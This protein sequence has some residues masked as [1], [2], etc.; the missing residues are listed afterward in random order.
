MV[1]KIGRGNHLKGVLIYNYEKVEQD[2]GNVLCCN[3]MIEPLSG[4]FTIPL[5]E[6]SFENYLIANNKTEKPILHISLNPNPKDK[7]SDKQFE[8]IAQKYMDEMGYGNQPYVVFSHTDI[9]RK[10]IHIVS[11]CV[12]ENGKRISDSFEKR[13][14]M[15]VCRNL[16]KEF[17]LLPA[18]SSENDKELIPLNKVDAQQPNL[19]KQIASALYFVNENYHFQTLGEYKAMLSFFNITAEEVKGTIDGQEKRGLVYF[20]TD[21][22]G[23]KTSHAFKSSRFSGGFSLPDLDKKYQK[24]KVFIGKNKPQKRLREVVQKAMQNT[25]TLSDFKQSLEKEKIS[26][27]VRENEQ[28]RIY[29]VSFIDHTSKTVMNGSRLGKEFSANVFHQKWNEPID[30]KSKNEM[31]ISKEIPTNETYEHQDFNSKYD[32]HTWEGLAWLLPTDIPE[33]NDNYLQKK[34]RKKKKN[35]KRR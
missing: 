26:V 19:K 20:A 3:K 17:G 1:A 33:E 23:K 25:K 21:D 12:D 29:G 7:V 9:A 22:K 2:K 8:Q 10:H 32:E 16:E 27:F 11:V 30:E 31:E 15:K 13:R 6:K 5:L 28:G 14:S 18:I 35:A 4:D 34:K 24:S